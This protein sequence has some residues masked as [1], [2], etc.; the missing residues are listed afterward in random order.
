LQATR[1]LANILLGHPQFA[2]NWGRTVVQHSVSSS[3]IRCLMR[4]YVLDGSLDSGEVIW[5]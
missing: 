4:V 2:R 3:S 1:V 5:A